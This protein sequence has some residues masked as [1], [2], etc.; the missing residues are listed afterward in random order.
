MRRIVIVGSGLAGHTAALEISRRSPACQVTVIGAEV[1]LP[2]DRPPLSKEYLLADEPRFPGLS[3]GA[4]YGD[5]TELVDGVRASDIDR[6]NKS[7]GLTNGERLSYDTLLLTTGS[8]VRR[9]PDHPGSGRVRYLRDMDDAQLLRDAIRKSERIAVLG[10]GFIGLEVAAAARQLNKA[11]I[12]IERMERLLQ[13]AASQTLSD[14]VLKRHQEQ[15]VEV[16]LNTSVGRVVEADTGVALHLDDRIVEVDLLLIGIGIQPNTELAEKAG[17][18]VENGI[19]VDECCRTSDPDIFAAGEVTQYPVAAIGARLR[20]E[21]WSAAGA[22]AKVAAQNIV[23]GDVKFDE[24]PW[25]WSDQ[26]GDNIQSLGLQSLAT[27]F[28][29]FDDPSESKWMRIGLDESDAV[30]CAEAVNLGREMSSLR[31]SL[32]S[33]GGIP[34]NLSALVAVAEPRR[35][36]EMAL[37]TSGKGG[38]SQ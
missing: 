2:Y 17:L 36:A 38:M 16:L 25:F 33:G 22:Q 31:R 10:G 13:R 29:G 21:S 23:G 5:V 1:G 3:Q 15:G 20:S 37:A 26:Y 19:V 11:V 7:V 34:E 30:V 18:V 27:R 9:L 8:R 4:I 14:F 28:L 6:L 12:V 24:L 32:K 35:H